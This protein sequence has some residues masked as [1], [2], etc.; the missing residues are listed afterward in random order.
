MSL[1]NMSPEDLQA[2][3]DPST[4]AK[5]GRY[6]AGIPRNILWDNTEFSLFDTKGVLPSVDMLILWCDS[7]PA[8][9][10]WTAK[11]LF[12]RIVAAE[13]AHTLGRQVRM[14]KLERVNHFVSGNSYGLIP[15]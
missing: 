1:D 3:A 14:V 15:R 5:S 6:L 12:E 11:S 10:I 9:C 2:A 13:R 7:S 4:L 8:V